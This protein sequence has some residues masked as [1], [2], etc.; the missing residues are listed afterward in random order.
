MEHII[1]D[2]NILIKAF[3]G[4]RNAGS[5]F[6]GNITY[7]SFITQI[8]LLSGKNQTN[9]QYQIIQEAL[10]QFIIHPYSLPL[11]EKVIKI[12]RTTGL[13]IPDAFIAASAIELRLPLFSGDDIFSKVHGVNFFHVGF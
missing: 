2:T 8:E 5:I 4:D 3:A 11:Q 7:I 12:R 1:I 9:K 13:K 10:S 6:E